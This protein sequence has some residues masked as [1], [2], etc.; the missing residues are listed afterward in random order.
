MRRPQGKSQ[1]R[2]LATNYF[3]RIAPGEWSIL[4]AGA[5]YGGRWGIPM[6]EKLSAILDALAADGIHVDHKSSGSPVNAQLHLLGDVRRWRSSVKTGDYWFGSRGGSVKGVVA[7]SRLIRL[8]QLKGS[9][10]TARAWGLTSK[11]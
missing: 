8:L 9:P 10:R 11:D 1:R 2:Q 6:N 5:M 4:G 3:R 7:L